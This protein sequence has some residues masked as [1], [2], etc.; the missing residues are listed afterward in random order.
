MVNDGS[1]DSSEDICLSFAQNDSRF[2]YIRKENGGVSSARNVGLAVSSGEYVI[3]C[4]SDDWVDEDMCEWLYQLVNKNDADVGIC[5]LYVDTSGKI[6]FQ[7]QSEEVICYNSHDSIVEMHKGER[8]AGHP[9]GKIFKQDVVSKVRFNEQIAILEDMVFVWEVFNRCEKIVYQ[10]VSKYHYIQYSNS[11][12]YSFKDSFWS[13]QTACRIM[14]QYMD[15]NY[16]ESIAWAQ[17]T[18]IVGN[19]ILARRLCENHNLTNVEYKLVKNEILKNYNGDSFS[20]LPT[21]YALGFL[22]FKW[23][24]ILYCLYIALLTQK[25]K[26]IKRLKG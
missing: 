26:F 12:F 1:T 4:D 21:E 11:S 22:I 24:R 17:K 8:F 10:G 15:V 13:I 23:S 2:K 9:F 20:K 5:A 7:M 18:A 25:R 6:G 19:M 16:P 3:F 14:V